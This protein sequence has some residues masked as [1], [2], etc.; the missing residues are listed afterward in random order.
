MTC[1]TLHLLQEFFHFSGKVNSSYDP[2]R[3]LYYPKK[4]LSVGKTFKCQLHFEQYIR[5]KRVCF[6]IKRYGL[7]SS[8]GT[9]NFSVNSRKRIFHNGDNNSDIS[10][11]ERIPFD[12]LFFFLLLVTPDIPPVSGNNDAIKRLS[13]VRYFSLKK[14]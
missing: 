4:Q 2:N 8:N 12:K 14:L 9:F 13:S 1:D 5:T 7:T 11:P 3:K 10:A 6:E